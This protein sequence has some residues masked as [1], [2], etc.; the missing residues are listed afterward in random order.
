MEEW[1]YGRMEH[2]YGRMEVWKNGSS[3]SFSR[4]PSTVPALA[5]STVNKKGPRFAGPFL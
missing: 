4:Q 1:K 2:K 5:G 3:L